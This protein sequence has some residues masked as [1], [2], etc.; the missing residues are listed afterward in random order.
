MQP[1]QP[2]R[3]LLLVSAAFFVLTC[4]GSGAH[5]FAQQYLEKRVARCDGSTYSQWMSS[6][7]E[8]KD[9]DWEIESKDISEAERLNGVEYSGKILVHWSALRISYGRCWLAWEEFAYGGQQ[10]LPFAIDIVKTNGE[11]S[12]SPWFPAASF[13]SNTAPDCSTVEKI[14]TWSPKCE[15]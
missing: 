11:W 9:L 13:E 3:V 10:V 2:T 7:V 14:P 4:G 5:E 15:K 12:A 6:T 1:T 8:V